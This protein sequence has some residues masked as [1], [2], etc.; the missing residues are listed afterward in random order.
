M[1][2]ELSRY[3]IVPLLALGAACAGGLARGA[4]LADVAGIAA[5]VRTGS[6]VS[7]PTHIIFDW[8]Y[9]DSRGPLRG[10]GAAR[11]NPPDLF[12][13]DLFS[14]GNGSLSA[15]LVDDR[16]RS[17]GELEDFQLPPPAFLYAMAGVFRPGSDVPRGGFES[18]EYRVL[19]YA[20]EGG[21]QVYF[22]L[23]G[24]RLTRVEERRGARVERRIEITWGPD[25][26]WPREARYRDDVNENRV[27]WELV[28]LRTQPEPYASDTYELPGIP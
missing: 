21:S 24:E 27:R 10:E 22:Y 7:Q 12:R 4:P 19:E 5:T 8:D 17:D 13:L 25:P 14:S 20:G 2:S 28:R 11:V 26:H 9:A 3:A 16:V 18:G 15:V 6:G 23:S 1:M